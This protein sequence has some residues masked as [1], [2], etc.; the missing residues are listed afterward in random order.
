MNACWIFSVLFA[1]ITSTEM[2]I[3]LFPFNLVNI[4]GG[5]DRFFW[6]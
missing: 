4:Y 5:T 2:F 6:C 3:E 1:S